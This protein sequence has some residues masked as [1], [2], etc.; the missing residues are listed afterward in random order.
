MSEGSKSESRG[1]VAGHIKFLACVADDAHS[2]TAAYFAGRRALN[3]SGRVAILHVLPPPEFQHWVAVG[4]LM[5]DETRE[6]AEDFLQQIA[7]EIYDRVGIMPEYYLREGAIGEEILHQLDEDPG[8]DML[9][10]GAAPADQRG[11]KLISWLAGQLAGSLNVPLIV[12]P[13]NLTNE[14]IENLT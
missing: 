14:Q 8:I 9:V 2:R 6:E 12:V 5:R 1:H 13:G 10:V 3:C 4:D 7:G 11:G